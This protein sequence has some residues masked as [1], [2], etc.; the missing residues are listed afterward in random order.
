MGVAPFHA[1]LDEGL[2]VDG[3]V[4]C[5]SNM[6]ERNRSLFEEIAQE[7]YENYMVTVDIYVFFTFNNLIICLEHY[8]FH[9]TTNNCSYILK[10]PLRCRSRPISSLAN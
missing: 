10:L 3:A 5:F 1:L 9:C 8:I 6:D 4:V 7:I 2:D